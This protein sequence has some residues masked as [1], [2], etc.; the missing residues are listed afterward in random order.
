MPLPVII[1]WTGVGAPLDWRAGALFLLVF[2]WQF[3][4][5]MAIAWLYRR[6]YA[7]ANLRM[8]T[9]VDS[10]GYWAAILS[11]AAASCLIVVSLWPLG[12][13]TS[14]SWI[15]LLATCM[16]GAGQLVSAAQFLATRQDS[17]ARRLLR[18]SLIYLP[19]QLV[20]FTLLHLAV[21]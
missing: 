16:L 9:V 4:H 21:I 20:L 19:L 6:Q 2:L 17:S 18:A 1:G 15:Y 3:P 7:A 8:M 11:V 13:L 10:T 12:Q 5:F 14:I